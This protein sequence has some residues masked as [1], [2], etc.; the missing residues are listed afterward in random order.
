MVHGATM[1]RTVEAPTDPA[2][3]RSERLTAAR[4][5]VVKI[6]TGVLTGPGGGIDRAV[7]QALATEMATL[8]SPTRTTGTAG[9]T[10]AA[11][12]TESLRRFV[13][14]SSGAIALGV[15]QLGMTA[16]P[17]KMD[18]LQACAAVGQGHL[19]RL[20]GEVFAGHGRVVAQVLLTHAD[21]ADR[22]RFLNAR[23]AL[24]ELLRR[25]AVPVI[26]E[27][28]TVAVEEIAFG[29]NDSLSAQ[30][31]NLV[32]ADLLVMLSVAPA[33]LDGATR[34]SVVVPGDRTVDGFIRTDTS[35]GGTGGMV[36]KVRAARAATG[37]GCTAVIAEGKRP[38]VLTELLAGGD[39]GT[40]FL[41]ESAQLRSRAHWILHTLRPRGALVVDDGARKAVVDGNR[42]LLPSGVTE[43]RGAFGQGDP[44]DL[45]G[46]DGIAFARGLSAYSAG[47]IQKLQGRQTTEIQD[48]LGYH[49]G[50]EAVHRDDLVL[51]G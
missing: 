5:V 44:V 7:L 26:N 3:A 51:L 2:D 39:L 20:W 29:D 22:R 13:V 48:I 31:A 46:S 9:A 40:V 21:L 10:G 30:V 27:N 16:R 6:G 1:S 4:T 36:T 23:R 19:I 14:V 18:A 34:V 49:L 38:G 32:H 45:V 37:V 41:P 24:S 28:D 11:G 17:R 12:T 43:V 35:T 15:E 50:D 8:T 33:L 47:E 25:G 42:S